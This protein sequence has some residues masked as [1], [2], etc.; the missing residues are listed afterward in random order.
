MRAVA[1]STNRRAIRWLRAQLPALASA[2]VLSAE[3][4]AAIERYYAAEE[5]E[6]KNIGFVILASIGSALVASGIILLIAHN[7]DEFSRPLRTFIAFLP[8]LVAQT[9]AVFVLV[10]RA[11]SKS[12]RES[13]AI[14]DVAAVATAISLISQAYQIQ[15]SFADF[16]MVWLFLSLPIVY[17]FRTTLGAVAYVVG[18]VVWLFNKSG[19][20][21]N[22]PEQLYFWLFLLA[23]VPYYAFLF[24]K[25]RL[26][27]QLVSLSVVLMAAMAIGLGWVAEDTRANVGAIAFAGFFTTVYLCGI[28]F[29]QS[30]DEHLST[31]ALLGGLGI[32]VV[33]VVLS[34]EDIWRFYGTSS[35]TLKDVPRAMGIAIQ[36]F[37]PI[38]AV[39]LLVW[40]YLDKGRAT[41]SVVAGVLPLVAG[42]AWIIAE[43]SSFAAAAVFNIF[44]LLLG[45]ELLA[46]GIRANSIARANFGLLVIVALALARFFDS[47]LSFL[48]RGLGF[49][50]VGAGFLVANVVLFKRRAKA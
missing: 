26:S 32:G 18:A 27:G 28:R 7:W 34:F 13:V 19:W 23:I 17:I 1:R 21:H 31:L 46:R 24:R 4:V 44:A 39:G 5:A 10:K 40:S 50:A 9:L 20:F 33:A 42:L 12:W 3:N 38:A 30:D 43:S 35:S 36:L 47:D 11:E 29:F 49:I 41:F 25:D 6:S 8:L 14:F 2:G 15:G 45:V 16:M 22:E 37:F 48:T